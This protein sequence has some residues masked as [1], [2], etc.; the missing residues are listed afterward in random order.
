AGAR[1]RPVAIPR[2]L[3]SR[4]SVRADMLPAV[5]RGL[6]F[7]LF[8]S[9]PLPAGHFGP[10]AP[11]MMAPIPPRRVAPPQVVRADAPFAALAELALSRR[12]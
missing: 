10:P 8:P 9:V 12:A 3:A 2:D 4:L 11:P 6:G 1:Q 7:R 5:L